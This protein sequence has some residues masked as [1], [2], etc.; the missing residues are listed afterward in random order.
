MLHVMEPRIAAPTSAA[1][2]A[3]TLS[4]TGWTLWNIST[5]LQQL[6]SSSC[7][8]CRSNATCVHHTPRMMS[9]CPQSFELHF[10]LSPKYAL[11]AS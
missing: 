2:C 6:L 3:I 10:E 1:S 4:T 7:R 5:S 9:C 11:N 8:A